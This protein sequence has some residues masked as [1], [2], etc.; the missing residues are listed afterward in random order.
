LSPREQQ[1]LGLLATGLSNKE[2]A[3]SI[4]VDPNTVKYHLKRMFAKLSV[5]RR[6]R[7]VMRARQYGLIN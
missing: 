3:R 1:I 7:A 4:A 2:I 5:E 6:G